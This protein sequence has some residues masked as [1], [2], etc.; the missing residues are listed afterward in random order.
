ML[1]FAGRIP[2]PSVVR[3]PLPKALIAAALLALAAAPSA[4]AADTASSSNWAGYAV[5]RAGVR[6]TKVVGSWTQPSA[7]CVAGKQGYSAIWLGLGGFAQS[8]NALEQIGSEV[9]CT[10]A[11]KVSS[12]AWYELVPAAS[13]PIS[14]KVKPGD[15]LSATVS[16]TGHRVV[17]SLVDSTS[18]RSFKKVLQASVVDVSSAE[19]ILEAPSDCISATSCQTLPL[20]D[21]GSAN[22]AQSRAQSVSGHVGSISDRAWGATKIQLRPSGRRFVVLNGSG[23]TVGTATPSA[24]NPRGTSFTVAYSPAPVQ[25][26]QSLAARTTAVR[27]GQLVHPRR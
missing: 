11:G 12:S 18:H 8:S 3:V 21:F 25:A 6:F 15:A 14:M 16:V 17:L 20:A 13:R 22:F 26:T 9:D 2:K 19:W 1:K 24:L 4:A 27:A 5:H 7:T 23:P 10:A